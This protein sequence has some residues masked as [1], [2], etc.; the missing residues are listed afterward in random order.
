[1]FRRVLRLTVKLGIIAAVG[2]GIAVVVKKLTA[3]PADSSGSLEP[4]PP[5]KTDASTG[6]ESSNGDSAPASEATEEEA[7]SNS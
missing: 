3:A 6:D 7:A 4:W 1:M 5:L 2:I